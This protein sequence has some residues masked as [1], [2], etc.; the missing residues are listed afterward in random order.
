MSNEMSIFAIANLVCLCLALVLYFYVWIPLALDE[1][2]QE[3][4]RIRDRLFVLAGDPSRPV[5][6]DDAV[7][8]DLRSTLNGVITYAHV[9]SYRYMLIFRIMG[10]LRFFTGGTRS[11]EF[12]R[13]DQLLI[14]NQKDP[15]IIELV[16]E[17]VSSIGLALFKL[18]LK[19]SGIYL[20]QFICG[21]L[22][23]LGSASLQSFKEFLAEPDSEPEFDRK[24]RTVMTQA[25]FLEHQE[26]AAA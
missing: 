10:A 21:F 12:F 5:T 13:S 8:K 1:F 6:R 18:Y 4:F 26:I 15:D 7:Y 25:N 23:A 14:F 11:K 20:I 3:I 17:V 19:T 22:W 2:R 9:L 16:D 24:V